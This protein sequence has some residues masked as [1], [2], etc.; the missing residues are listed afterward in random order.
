MLSACLSNV[1]FEI[2]IL[3]DLSLIMIESDRVQMHGL[4]Q[5]MGCSIVR[6]E[7]SQPEKRSRLWL[8][9]DSGEVFVIKSVRNSLPKVLIVYLFLGLHVI[10][11][12][13]YSK[14]SV[15]LNY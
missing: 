3:M 6:N 15:M 10:R 7:S 9:Q 14:L 11:N 1:D 2:M 4:I 8:V 13:C 12:I 5:Q